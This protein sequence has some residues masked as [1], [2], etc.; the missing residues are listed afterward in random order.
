MLLE[1]APENDVAAE[2]SSTADRCPPRG[3]CW[4]SVLSSRE[5]ANWANGASLSRDRRRFLVA[6]Q[7]ATAVAAAA[8]S[9]PGQNEA[10]FVAKEFRFLS[11]ETLPDVRLHYVTLGTPQRDSQGK[12][13]NA[14]LLLHGTS[15]TS[16]QWFVPT[17]A[18]ELFGPGQPLDAARYYV[19]MP[20]GLGRGGSTKPSDGVRGR[21]PRYGYGDV[22]AAQHLLVTS[23]LGIEHLRAVVGTSM[24]GMHAWM[25]AERFPDMMDV[26]MPIACQPSAISGRNLVFRRILTQAIRTDPDGRNGDYVDPPRH[27]LATAP[28]WPMMFENVVRL[29]ETAPTRQA[30]IERYDKWVEV[31]RRDYDANDFLYWVE[32]SFDYDP[33]T[34]PRQDQGEGGGGGL[35]RRCREPAGAAADRVTRAERAGRE[36]GPRTGERQDPGTPHAPPRRGVEALLGGGA[37]GAL[38]RPLRSREQEIRIEPDPVASCAVRLRR[39]FHLRVDEPRRSVR[40]RRMPATDRALDSEI[41]GMRQRPAIQEKRAHGVRFPSLSGGHHVDAPPSQGSD[42]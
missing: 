27:W 7:S 32:S 20:D 23:G 15:S 16:K 29:Q 14:V 10:D 1:R 12:V 42:R 24:G 13:A 2:A 4:R 40:G 36:V 37:G 33:A 30:A 41:T 39:S 19:I 17:M 8:S 21:F 25:W 28:L 34:G 38:R 31:A 35:R 5:H 3:A 26:A 18:P 22:V 11:G 9:Y 6:A